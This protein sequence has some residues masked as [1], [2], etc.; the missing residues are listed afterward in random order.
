MSS[1]PASSA[2]IA[3]NDHFD[4]SRSSYLGQINQSELKPPLP[5]SNS[6]PQRY[7]RERARSLSNS[8]SVMR[9]KYAR[10]SRRRLTSEDTTNSFQSDEGRKS[11]VILLYTMNGG[12][13]SGKCSSDFGIDTN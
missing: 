4:E 13:V 9:Q 12:C 5:R 7:C 8:V 11:S 1:S 2:A 3:E 10:R 6:A